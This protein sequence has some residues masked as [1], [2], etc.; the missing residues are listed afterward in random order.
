[1]APRLSRAKTAH[2]VLDRKLLSP[3]PN[4]AWKQLEEALGIR[5]P[6]AVRT[7]IRAACRDFTEAL[8]FERAGRERLNLAPRKGPDGRS[9]ETSAL[10]R[11]L[12]KLL[13]CDEAFR[14]AHQHIESANALIEFGSHLSVK[15]KRML[16]LSALRNDIGAIAYALKDWLHF[17][18]T[19][20]DDPTTTAHRLTPFAHFVKNLSLIIAKA[21]GKVSHTGRSYEGASGTSFQNF[22]SLINRFLPESKPANSAAALNKMI[23]RALKS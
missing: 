14:A 16:D 11:L 21:G 22:V 19:P 10:S 5:L 6:H 8:H 18:T 15:S 23:V 4:G 17:E 13:E 7:E 3:F 2:V 20:D 12:Q 1:M 9:R